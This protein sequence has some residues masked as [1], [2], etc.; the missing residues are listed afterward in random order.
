M[1]ILSLYLKINL[2]ARKIHILPNISSH[3]HWAS[4]WECVVP[5]KTSISLVLFPHWRLNES[6]RPKCCVL[7]GSR[8]TKSPQKRRL[9]KNRMHCLLTT[10]DTAGMC[11]NWTVVEILTLAVTNVIEFILLCFGIQN[12]ILYGSVQQL[13][14]I[15]T[16]KCFY[17]KTN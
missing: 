1:K 8:W 5:S 2:R 6:L 16:C 10:G 15:E 12:K 7:K 13:F 3:I 9:F 14:W 11:S 17:S 4:D